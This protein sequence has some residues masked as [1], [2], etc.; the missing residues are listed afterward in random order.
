MRPFQLLYV[1]A[2][3]AL[4]SH[5]S[6]VPVDSTG[7]V[8]ASDSSSAE[9]EEAPATAEENK[10]PTT[11]GPNSDDLESSNSQPEASYVVSHRI[12]ASLLYRLLIKKFNAFTAAR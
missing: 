11:P 1:T 9:P 7:N 8:A 2:I 12:A 6:A 3:L 5:I 10:A 4:G